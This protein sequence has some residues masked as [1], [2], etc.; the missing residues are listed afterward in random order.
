M[1]QGVVSFL[2][3]RPMMFLIEKAQLKKLTFRSYV[4]CCFV[5]N[6]SLSDIEG[7]KGGWIID[8]GISSHCLC[9]CFWCIG[10]IASVPHKT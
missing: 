2:I 8:E 10:D 7:T 1:I 6:I 5:S 4:L 3:M 9:F